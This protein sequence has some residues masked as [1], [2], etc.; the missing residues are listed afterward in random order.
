MADKKIVAK[1]AA[2]NYQKRAIA[3]ALSANACRVFNLSTRCVQ[4]ITGI[5][6]FRGFGESYCQTIF[7]YYV[8]I[9]APE[10]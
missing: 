1:T 4:K 8:G 6:L 7:F 9:H 3:R 2:D 10:V 5:F